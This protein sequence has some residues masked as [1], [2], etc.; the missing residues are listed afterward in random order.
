[1]CK[2]VEI[3]KFTF[4]H[5]LQM[6]TEI[7]LHSSY[8]DNLSLN[9]S[10]FVLRLLGDITLQSGTDFCSSL[11]SLDKRD[12]D[13]IPV[14]IQS[15]GG[16]VDA[17][18]SIIQAMEQ[19]VTPIATICSGNC[20]SAGAVIFC[21]GSNG[22]RYMGPNSYVMFH[23]YSMGF[24]EAKGSDI[25]ALQ[26]HCTKIDRMI[27]RKMEKHMGLETNFFENLGHVDAYFT[28]KDAQKCGI[29]NHVGYPI[30]RVNI[31]LQ[32]NMVLKPGKRQEIEE[33]ERRPF[34]FAKLI[35]DPHVTR[36][37]IVI[38]EE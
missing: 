12:L 31:G 1:M 21:M 27:N 4:S 38:E 22:H 19:C 5:Y 6:N 37:A 24:G 25:Q 10:D 32:M 16:D 20:L 7:R 11:F 34:K 29:V 14:V 2:L 9:S 35:I 18:L 28:A 30:L 17:L 26:K 36:D 23:E 15:Q 8:L 33:S 13:F 3:F